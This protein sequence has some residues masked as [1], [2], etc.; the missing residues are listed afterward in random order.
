MDKDCKKEAGTQ[1]HPHTTVHSNALATAVRRGLDLGNGSREA[2]RPSYSQHLS[3]F[4]H[5]DKNTA[6]K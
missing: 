5:Q 3:D 6:A 2:V 1:D 4:Q